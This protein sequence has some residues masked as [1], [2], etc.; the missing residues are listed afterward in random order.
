MTLRTIMQEL[1]TEF[2]RLTTSLLIDDFNGVEDAKVIQGHPL[3]DEIVAAI[4]NKL[5]TDF[6]AF[7]SVDEQSHQAA[8]ELSN[9][10]AAKDASGSAKAFGHLTEGCVSCHQQFREALRP[11]SD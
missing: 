6:H 4:K 7:E 8:A 2:L 1:G 5:G 3:P 9:R 11:L 10:A